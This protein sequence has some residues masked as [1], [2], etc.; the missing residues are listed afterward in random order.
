MEEYE[1]NE[2]IF[3]DANLTILPLCC[4]S[5]FYLCIFLYRRYQVKYGR[6]I[7]SPNGDYSAQVY[8]DNYGGAIGG[9]NLIVN[10]IYHQKHDE[11]QTIYF[12][13]AKGSVNVNWTA[14]DVLSITNYDEYANRN[15]EL[16]VG[17]EIYDEQGTACNT[18]KI[19][20]AFKCKDQDS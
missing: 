10:I 18:Y 7:L 20:K 11:E 2:F 5:P 3:V 6:P 8:Y 13:D 15:T 9:V 1:K 12:S 14:D 16:V 4:L 19:R 17:K